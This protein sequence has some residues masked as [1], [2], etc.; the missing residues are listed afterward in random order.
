VFSAL[1]FIATFAML[2]VLFRAY[3]RRAL[4]VLP[5][6][7]LGVVWFSVA[8]VQ[9]ALWS[10]QLAWYL[11]LFFF[12]AMCGFLLG[13]RRYP[14]AFLGIAIVAAVLASLTEV[15]GFAVWA[16][17]LVCL[18][19]ETPRTRRTAYEIATWMSVAI[20]T[21]GIYLVGLDT[22]SGKATCMIE[23]GDPARC[24]T[25]YGLTHPVDLAKFLTALVGNVVPTLRG[26]WIWAH[27][28]LG[29]ALGAAAV[30]V[31]IQVFRERRLRPY[32]LPA[33]LIVFALQFDLMVALS[34]LGLGT[35]AAGVNRY[36]MPNLVLLCGI[37]MYAAAQL[38]AGHSRRARPGSRPAMV[39][40]A[41][42]AAIVVVQGVVG[43]RFGITYGR[44]QKAFA[45][46]IA[47]VVVNYP[48]M[49]V[50]QRN[51]YLAAAIFTAPPSP[52]ARA[53]PVIPPDQIE[54]IEDAL[55][56]IRLK[57]VRNDLSLFHGDG[58]R[59]YRAAGPPPAAPVAW[60]HPGPTATCET[61]RPLE[62]DG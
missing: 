10:F 61:D 26:Q 22:S 7:A 58:D 5:V 54:G 12:V 41:A 49:P 19:W 34:R 45:V 38:P 40:V 36:T 4:T 47:R 59:R 1:I 18:V 28:L 3:L 24:S 16:A 13:R 35:N 30:Y 52:D 23:G 31:V 2:L 32:P 8:D 25:T 33:L 37:V 15:Q 62:D 55:R 44:A 50:D 6:L 60:W 11:V 29:V 20:V 9:N 14:R 46:D 56:L 48:H 17:G 39:L 51:C 53:A 42:V 43:T 57:L 27:Q 21:A